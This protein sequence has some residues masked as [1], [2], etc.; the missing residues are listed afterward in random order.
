M[1]LFYILTSTINKTLHERTI[2]K[3]KSGTP[4]EFPST[5]IPAKRGSTGRTL[6]LLKLKIGDLTVR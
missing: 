6:Q 4:Q 2:I 3:I 5:Q 1:K